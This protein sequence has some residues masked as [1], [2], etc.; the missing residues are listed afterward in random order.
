MPNATARANARTLP[1]ATN[2]RAVLGA[3]LAAGATA[4]LL[5][6]AAEGPSLSAVDK[7]VLALWADRAKLKAIGDR[8]DAAVD[9]LA[10]FELEFD[11]YLETSVLALGAALMI[12]GNL[13]E[14]A[15][16]LRCAA[17]RAIRPQLVGEIGEAADL[18]LASATTDEEAAR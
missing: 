9:A 12:Y 5:A 4:A 10:D 3:V 16:G 2:R 14:P 7:H 18:M 1:A 17:L 11:E 15:D 13:G 8:R 6:R